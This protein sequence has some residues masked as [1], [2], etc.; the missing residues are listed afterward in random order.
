MTVVTQKLNILTNKNGVMW[1]S[2]KSGS[3][4]RYINNQTQICIIYR[5]AK[6]WLLLFFYF[7][8]G[9]VIRLMVI[10]NSISTIPQ[11]SAFKIAKTA[12]TWWENPTHNSYEKDIKYIVFYKNKLL[13]LFFS[14]FSLNNGLHLGL[15]RICIVQSNIDIS[16]EFS[17][18]LR[19]SS[20]KN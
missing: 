7:F 11:W 18:L 17:R 14:V 5:S 2:L 1:Q 16:Y 9:G 20:L 13:Q 12:L 4:S 19:G 10:N 6:S 8:W 15:G 3:E